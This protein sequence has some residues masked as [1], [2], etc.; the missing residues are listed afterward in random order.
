MADKQLATQRR[1][2]LAVIH[3]ARGDNRQ[4]VDGNLFRRH[5]R[6]L[7]WLSQC[8]SLYERLIQVLGYR[9]T[10]SGSMRAMRPTGGWSP[11]VLRPFHAFG[12]FEYK[13]EPGKIENRAL[14]APVYSCLSASFIDMRQQPVN[15][16]T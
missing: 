2:N 11:P 6:A 8:G 10:H 4:T 3:L 7:R 12:G 9:F 13:P 14:R 16:A 5:H 1:V 15:N